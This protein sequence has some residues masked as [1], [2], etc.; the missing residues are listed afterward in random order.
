MALPCTN[1]SSMKFL[2]SHQTKKLQEDAK[3]IQF[4]ALRLP[5]PDFVCNPHLCQSGNQSYS[6]LATLKCHRPPLAF[7]PASHPPPPPIRVWPGAIPPA[8]PPPFPFV[9]SS[10]PLP[11]SSPR[12]FV[13]SSSR[14]LLRRFPAC[15][16][17]PRPPKWAFGISTEGVSHGTPMDHRKKTRRP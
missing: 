9:S 2:R 12:R 4:S 14:R 11:V 10:R 5:P 17:K 6:F 13:V 15:L 1:R 7:F 8:P 16:F 3:N